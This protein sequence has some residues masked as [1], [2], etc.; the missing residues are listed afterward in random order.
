MYYRENGAQIAPCIV[1]QIRYA[2]RLKI[3]PANNSKQ[4][5]DTYWNEAALIIGNANNKNIIEIQE[6]FR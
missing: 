4:C 1:S 3:Q 2:L 5:S 6:I